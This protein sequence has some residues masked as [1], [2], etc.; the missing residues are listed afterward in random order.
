MISVLKE[1]L[2]ILYFFLNTLR[3]MT[4]LI[5]YNGTPIKILQK[6]TNF[7]CLK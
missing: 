5:E 1:F 4:S 7:R 3:D 2:N 6:S